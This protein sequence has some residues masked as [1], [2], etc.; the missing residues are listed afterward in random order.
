MENC[1]FCKIIKKEIPAEITYEDEN[2]VV[3]KD[4]NPDAPVHVLIVPKKHIESINELAE[5]D[6]ELAGRLLLIAKEI[7]KKLNVE[8][9]YKL[10]FNVGKE[11]GQLIPHLH[12]HLV[13]GRLSRW[14]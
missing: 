9:G 10:A 11:G 8:K 14:P 12:M 2:I 5:E 4:I 3:F 13:S 6:K 7:A 1:I